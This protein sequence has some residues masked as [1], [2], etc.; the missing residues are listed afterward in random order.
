MSEKPQQNFYHHDDKLVT[1][2]YF[3]KCAFRRKLDS[4]KEEE[5]GL[6]PVNKPGDDDEKVI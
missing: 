6:E 2:E 4:T 3:F 1:E 5:L